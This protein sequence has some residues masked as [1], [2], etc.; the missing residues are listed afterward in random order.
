MRKNLLFLSLLLCFALCSSGNIWAQG[1]TTS[2]LT[3]VITDATD[4]A[5]QLEDA[6]SGKITMDAVKLR[7]LSGARVTATH[8][9]SGTQYSTIS[10]AD[11][12]YNLKGL[13][14]GGPYTI[15]V[16]LVGYRKEELKDITL[17]LGENRRADIAVAAQDVTI[18]GIQV[19]ANR[20]K[21]ASRIGAGSEI[22]TAQLERTPNI[23]R[24]FQEMTRT[25]PLVV[26]SNVGAGD[27]VGGINIAGQNNRYNNVQ[28]DGAV[29]NDLFGLSSTGTPGGQAAAQPI[30][31]DAIEQMQ[32]SVAPFDV[33]QSGFTGGLVNSVTRS[34][35]NTMT[36]SAYFLFRNQA[37]SGLSPSDDEAQRK[38]LSA[39]SDFTVGARLGGAI[40]QDKLFFFA[41]VETRRVS[42][43]LELA[44]NQPGAALNFNVPRETIDR[45]INIARTRYNYNPGNYDTFN[46]QIADVKGFL[47]LDWNI[48][49][50][51]RL[52]VRHNIVSATQDRGVDRTP[53]AL[54]LSG[55]KYVFSS[56]QNNTVVQLNSTFGSE[57]ANELRVS[58]MSINDRR[59]DFAGGVFPFVSIGVG[60]GGQVVTMG[61]EPFSQA[62]LLNQSI[63]EITDDFTLFAGNHSITIGTHNEIYS[64]ANVFFPWY[65]GN[66][67]FGSVDDFERGTPFGYIN[68]FSTDVARYGSTPT[69]N[70]TSAQLG[71]Y[72]QDEWDVSRVLRL[73]G[74]VRADVF[75]LPT[76]P[77]FNPAAQQAFGRST[78]VVPNAAILLAPRV[79]FDLDLSDGNR[80]TKLRGGTGIFTGRSPIVW[81]SN[82][83]SNTGVDISTNFIFNGSVTRERYPMQFMNPNNPP[84]QQT[85][86]T[87]GNYFATVNFIDPNFRLPQTWR[88]SLAFEQQLP[89]GF[90]ASLEGVYSKLLNQPLYQNLRLGSSRANAIDGRPIFNRD[91]GMGMVAG[92]F[93]DAFLLTNTQE[94]YQFNIIAQVQK[95]IGYAGTKDDAGLEVWKNLGLNL[96]YTYGESW[97]VNSNPGFIADEN[98]FVPARDPNNLPLTRSLFDIPHRIVAYLSYKF[99]YGGDN[100]FAT[101]VSLRYEG[102]SG[103]TFSYVYNGDP[104]NLGGLF[105][106]PVN[107]ALFFV[108][109]DRNQVSMSDAAWN[110]MNTFITNDPVLSQYR[111]QFVPRNAGREPWVNELDLSV[112]QDIPTGIG[113]IQLTAN[114]FNVLN[115]L[116]PSWGYIQFV[117]RPSQGDFSGQTR[118]GIARFTGYEPDGRMR[119]DF[120]TPQGNTV[121]VR[122]N[123]LSRW[124]MQIGVRYIF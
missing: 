3:G 102:R 83:Y 111:G 114:I 64:S 108:P 92:S 99:A 13:R 86:L 80:Q 34:G 20:E 110:A 46:Q 87:P 40:V 22:S 51:H 36:G 95:P 73:T 122:D 93:G 124:Q 100:G 74:G 27:N 57:A 42:Q 37:L 68:R 53:L 9:P 89:L 54:S 15:T 17:G 44:I 56:V 63:L 76:Q 21:A 81:L 43:P 112:L 31:L 67:L 116:N 66:Y 84:A 48:S 4:Y 58:Y 6:L 47:R 90:T 91:G 25:N 14:V 32:V 65:F 113:R 117:T 82:Q 79:G 62:N 41:N 71:L 101:T 61:V 98:F 85:G 50:E 115:L 24:S 78:S 30:S 69:A 103:R 118:Y 72:I 97:D 88:S 59:G 11:G 35:T 49:D 1:V 19:T 29:I 39:F 75:L 96:A 120:Q 109:R 119:L 107:H 70:F 77:Y 38:P 104:A 12:N 2:A 28:V 5:Q 8:V 60:S 33:R 123:L 26:G 45:I 55:L 105:G 52:T 94:G 23:S 16:T 106:E 10:R 121:F 7:G 18:K